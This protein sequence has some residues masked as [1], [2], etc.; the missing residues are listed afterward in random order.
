MK[1][2][3][4]AVR[5]QEAESSRRPKSCVSCDRYELQFTVQPYCRLARVQVPLWPSIPRT[6]KEIRWRSPTF[7]LDVIYS[8]LNDTEKLVVVLNMSEEA[9]VSRG[10][11]SPDIDRPNMSEE[12]TVS[13]GS[14]QIDRPDM[15]MRRMVLVGKTGAGK[16][17]SGN[18]ILGR[19]GFKA[20]KSGSSI[21]KECWKE[22]E[23]VAETQVVLVDTP[24]LFDTTFSERD[25][26]REL[27]KCI[28]MTAPGP[29]AIIL[30]I[31]L[32]PF[33]M[34]EHLA[35]EKIRA[36]FGEE[37]DKYTMI[38]FTHGDEFPGA[39]EEHLEKAP[40]QLKRL[41]ELCGRRYHVF[42]NNKTDDRTQVLKFLNK[43]EHMLALN[44]VGLNVKG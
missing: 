38:L 27:S 32:G 8:H 34:E 1:S 43:V 21:T 12:E 41:L 11:R 7:N 35:I 19:M 36:I 18:T 42:D 33:T 23:L 29:H 28:S 30:V 14:P 5:Y 4:S 13:R 24:G 16:S 22:T 6:L 31:Q 17:S 26:K 37:A 25:L 9:I 15:P 20:A 39:I 2:V 3:L 44:G 40:K 10:R